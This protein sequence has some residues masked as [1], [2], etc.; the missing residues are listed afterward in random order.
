[1][2][3][4]LVRVDDRLIHGQV[5]LGWAPALNA[6]QILLVDDRVSSTEWERELYRMGVPPRMEVEFSS[7][8]DA[9]A[10]LDRWA[11]SER[12]TIVVIADVDTLVRVCS[13]SDSVRR[14]N[15]GGLHEATGRRKRLP[16]VFLSDEETE[17]LKA[18]SER[19]I[20]I[21]A[22]DVPTAKPISLK[23]FA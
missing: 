18:L 23:E 1:M 11:E 13:V 6:D 20:E 14:V 15:I 8:A 16:Y 9:P 3:L 5:V 17:R 21:T 2:S 10:A 12:R 7:V 4:N 22:R 19:G